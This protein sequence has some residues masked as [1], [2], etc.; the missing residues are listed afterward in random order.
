MGSVSTVEI[1]PLFETT[2]A[3]FSA[4]FSCLLSFNLLAFN[5]G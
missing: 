2:S 3:A 4:I 1:A 5:M